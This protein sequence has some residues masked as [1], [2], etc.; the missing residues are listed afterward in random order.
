MH[1][2]LFTIREACFTFDPLPQWRGTSP[3]RKRTN[4]TKEN[5]APLVDELGELKAAIAELCEKEKELKTILAASGYAEID[6]TLFRATVSLSERTTLESEKVRALLSAAQIAACS[7]TTEVTTVRV[8]AR[9]RATGS[10]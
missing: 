9:K 2:Y 7:K 3:E 1:F 4:M 6:G 5:L 8:A 10:K